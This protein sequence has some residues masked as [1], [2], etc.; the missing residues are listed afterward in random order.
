MTPDLSAF[1]NSRYHPGRPHAVQALWFFFGLPLLRCGVIPMSAFRVL[2][3]RLFGAQIG[4]G[5]VIK[6]SVRVKYPWRLRVGAHSWIGEDVWIDNLALVRVGSNVCISQGAYLC[7][8]NHD[9]SDPAFGLMVQPI[10]LEDGSWIGARAIVCPDV[11]VGPCGIAAAG[12]VLAKDIPPFE[13]HAGNPASF[14]RYRHLPH[15]LPADQ[16]VLRA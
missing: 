10:I 6:P 1:D 4:R 12:S 14:V 15:A 13:I 9:W 3:L 7:T 8:G 11:S 16:P 5:V 2:L